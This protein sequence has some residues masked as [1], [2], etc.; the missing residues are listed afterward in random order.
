MN[1]LSWEMSKDIIT[2]R[3]DYRGLLKI[4]LFLMLSNQDCSPFFLIILF[5]YIS[6]DIPLTS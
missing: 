3:D 6:N 5:I 1:F 2:V 4:Y